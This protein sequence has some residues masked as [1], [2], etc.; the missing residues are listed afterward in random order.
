[1]GRPAAEAILEAG[2]CSVVHADIP[3]TGVGGG[4][5]Y[6]EKTVVRIILHKSASAACIAGAV[7]VILCHNL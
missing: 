1:M 7:G 2:F 6:A 4:F 5:P 3:L